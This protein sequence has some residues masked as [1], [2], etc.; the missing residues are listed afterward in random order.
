MSDAD[1]S[2]DLRD[3]FWRSVG[4]LGSH[5]D[6]GAG[7]GRRDEPALWPGGAA[8]YLRVLTEHTGIVATDGLSAPTDDAPAGL[9]IELSVEGRELAGTPGESQLPVE[10]RWLVDALAEVAGAVAGAGDSL[11]KARREEELLS[12]EIGGAGAPA[13]RKSVV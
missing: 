7:P 3:D 11:A 10:A 5:L 1:R 13:D 8:D 6:L 2:Q 12:V 9:G 4:M